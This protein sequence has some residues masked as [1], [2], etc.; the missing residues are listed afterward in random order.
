MKDNRHLTAKLTLNHG[1][2]CCQF[3]TCD[4]THEY[5]RLNAEYTT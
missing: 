4:L 1:T 2:A 5:V 3:W